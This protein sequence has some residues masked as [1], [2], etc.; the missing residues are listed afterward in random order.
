MR[1]RA[2]TA[3]TLACLC[4]GDALN[5]WQPRLGSR[6]ATLRPSKRALQA[7]LDDQVEDTLCLSGDVV[8]LFL[9]SYTQRSIDTVYSLF[10]QPDDVLEAFANPNF[11]ATCLALAW[12]LAALPL[13][14]W[15]FDNSRNG[16]RRALETAAKCGFSALALLAAGLA[17]RAN[18]LGIDLDA[19]DFGFAAG[20]LPILGS[21]RYVLADATSKAE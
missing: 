20:I 6:P 10:E 13:R 21:W 16:T 1:R 2:F 9:Y 8:V 15:R 14:A 18:I 17:L 3:I 19:A 11:G 5:G 4:V 12:C 7:R